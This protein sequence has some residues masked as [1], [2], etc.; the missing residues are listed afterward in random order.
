[1][2][3]WALKFMTCWHKCCHLAQNEIIS[4]F[5]LHFIN[6][7]VWQ[8]CNY[9]STNHKWKTLMNQN[10]NYKS[11]NHEWTILFFWTQSFCNG[12]LC[13]CLITVHAS[14]DTYTAHTHNT[15][16][17]HMHTA[18]THITHNTHNTCTQ[19]TH[20]TYTQHMHTG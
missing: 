6:V 11:V 12:S 15:Y 9:K 4:C 14:C 13:L 19:H 7:I 20:N 8:N 5:S 2:N 18:H 16:T 10:Y 3:D 1:M 17:Q